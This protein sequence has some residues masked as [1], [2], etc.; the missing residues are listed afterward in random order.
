MPSP[1]SIIEKL[2]WVFQTFVCPVSF[3]GL[4]N[5]RQKQLTLVFE[6]IVDLV[7]AVDFAESRQNLV[8]V[9][10]LVFFHLYPILIPI[11]AHV[12]YYT[13]IFLNSKCQLRK[14][15]ALF[16]FGAQVNCLGCLPFTS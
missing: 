11:Y 5:F 16:L 8:D 2:L 1:R 9:F 4:T 3:P 7:I 10:C 13:R 15:F 6:P 14:I 12:Q